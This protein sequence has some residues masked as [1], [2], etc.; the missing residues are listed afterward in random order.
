[1]L[2][3]GIGNTANNEL[4]AEE[5]AQG[6]ELLFDGKTLSN[7]K[8]VN[9]QSKNE[10]NTDLSPD[11]KVFPAD[12]SFGKT[13]GPRDIRSRNKYTDFEL[14]FDFKTT[15]NSG[16]YYRSLTGLNDAQGY[17]YGW[18]TGA[19]FALED[20]KTL[21]PWI[22]NGAAYE[23]MSAE[24]DSSYPYSTGKWNKAK[25]VVNKD[26]VE[27]WMNGI[28]VVAFRYW[29]ANF[30]AAMNG[31]GRGSQG[32]RSKWKDFAEFCRVNKGDKTG[33]IPSGYLGI[34]GDHAGNLNVRNM[35]IA[36]LPFNPV[37]ISQ[38][39]QKLLNQERENL[40]SQIG[41]FQGVDGV[42]SLSVPYTTPYELSLVNV[43]GMTVLETIRDSHARTIPLEKAR[44]KPGVYFLNLKV[45][46]I[47]FSKTLTLQ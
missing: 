12:S 8:W 40:R 38:A 4:T 7:T 44:F 35:K 32:A 2:P 6:F 1:M 17:N 9:Y 46:G 24:P 34:Q 23:L 18:Q 25:I 33:Y 3:F 14:R 43:E 37:S 19:E 45:Q 21:A 29:D 11:W 31:Q 30:T 13:G 22:R 47:A 20:N 36:S 16:V 10:T 26:S 5:I 41:L 42:A 15:G 28:K 27:H 39:H